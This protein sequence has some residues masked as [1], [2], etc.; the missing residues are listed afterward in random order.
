MDELSLYGIPVYD[1]ELIPDGEM[2][3]ISVLHDGEAR[4]L[5]QIVIR[6][7]VMKQDDES[8]A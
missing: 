4:T 6:G 7:I 5:K 3:I 1:T 2:R 8:D